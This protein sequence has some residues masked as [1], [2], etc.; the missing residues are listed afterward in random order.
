MFRRGTWILGWGGSK[1]VGPLLDA[2][3]NETTVVKYQNLQATN[4]AGQQR[5]GIDHRGR[6]YLEIPQWEFLSRALVK[7]ANF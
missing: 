2:T 4:L 3:R 7:R 1:L 6:E 5:C